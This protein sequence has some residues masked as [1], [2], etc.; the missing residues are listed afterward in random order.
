MA[1]IRT[2]KP[3][4]FRSRSLAKC[5]IGARLTFIGLWTECDAKGRGVADPRI[6]KG[7]LY[8]LD[9][10]ITHVEVQGWLKELRSTGHIGLYQVDGDWFYEIAKFTK[11]QAAAYRTG[12]G[13][14]PAPQPTPPAPPDDDLHDDEC[15]NVQVAQTP[16]TKRA[17]REGK[18]REG[19]G[20]LTPETSSKSLAL[21]PDPIASDKPTRG[22]DPLWDALDTELGNAA[23]TPERSLRGKTRKELAALQATPTD[24]RMRCAEYRRRWPTASLTDTALVKHWS[25]LAIPQASPNGLSGNSQALL[26]VMA[27]IEAQEATEANARLGSFIDASVREV[28]A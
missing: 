6:L 4:F 2:I 23:T 11:H 14:H 8:A 18:V 17:V 9:D 5:S 7:A 26:N 22:R 27:A 15:K 13:V 1:R 3:E 25:S 16:T 12:E 28:G 19:K 10:A 24:V 21:V 20:T